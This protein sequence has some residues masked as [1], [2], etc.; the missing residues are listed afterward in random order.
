VSSRLVDSFEPLGEPLLKLVALALLSWA[1]A[2]GHALAKVPV[3]FSLAVAK[4]SSGLVG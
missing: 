2:K 4:V 3:L 1:F